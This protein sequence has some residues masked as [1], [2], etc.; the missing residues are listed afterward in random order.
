MKWKKK[1]A[2]FLSMA[3][4]GYGM[5]EIWADSGHGTTASPVR[6]NEHRGLFLTIESAKK[7]ALRA[8]TENPTMRIKVVAATHAPDTVH[9][10]HDDA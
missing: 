7:V 2:N 6:I 10:L 3:E 5:W 9:R 8:A 1:P 4:N